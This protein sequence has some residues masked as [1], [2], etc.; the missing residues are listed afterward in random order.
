MLVYQ[1]LNQSVLARVP[2]TTKRL[3]DIGCGSGAFGQAVKERTGCYVEGITYSDAEAGLARRASDNVLVQD[4]NHF[5]PTNLG[6]F[7]CAVCS[8]VLEHLYA[9]ENLLVKLRSCLTPTAILLVAL[10]NILVWRQRWQFFTGR[11][12]YT[13]EGLMDRTHFRFFDFESASALLR[14]SGYQITSVEAEG[15]FP[16]TRFL[17][18]AVSQR[19]DKWAFGMATRFVWLPVRFHLQS[20]L[21]G[22]HLAKLL[23]CAW[24]LL[25]RRLLRSLCRR[26]IAPPCSSKAFVAL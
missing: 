22:E 9:P 16:Y 14:G 15:G 8:H 21:K 13:D 19:I 3:L 25:P 24:T 18:A 17:P 4:L 11:F 2:N 6:P 20:V 23:C 7:D 1:A 10:P 12:R 5:D 26:T